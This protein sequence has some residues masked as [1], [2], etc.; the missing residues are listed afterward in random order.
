MPLKDSSN[1][2]IQKKK[3][4]LFENSLESN[5]RSIN[6]KLVKAEKINFQ[7]FIKIQTYY[8]N[9]FGLNALLPNQGFLSAQIP[10]KQMSLQMS[11]LLMSYL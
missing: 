2:K 1:T 10:Y 9:Y 11:T 6:Y 7:H 3:N 4:H 5:D 8:K